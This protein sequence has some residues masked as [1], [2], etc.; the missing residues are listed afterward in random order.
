ME[1][2]LRGVYI[3]KKKIINPFNVKLLLIQMSD[4]KSSVRKNSVL[5]VQ[6]R[7][8]ERVNVRVSRLVDFVT[9]NTT[10]P[11]VIRIRVYY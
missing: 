4:K 7:N 11:F 5:I 6:E 8:I 3:V 2:K 1:I 9:E 10:H